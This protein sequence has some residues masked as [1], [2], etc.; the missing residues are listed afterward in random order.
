MSA[1]LDQPTAWH[2]RLAFR[3][4]AIGCRSCRRFYRQIRFLRRI[5]ARGDMYDLPDESTNSQLVLSPESRTRIREA[6]RKAKDE[7]EE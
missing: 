3:L 4:H 6:I 7:A 1:S 2:Q 5:A